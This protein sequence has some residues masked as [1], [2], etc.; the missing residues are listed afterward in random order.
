M[1]NKI[2]KSIIVVFSLV[3][4]MRVITMLTADCLYRMS[5]VAEEDKI[6]IDRGVACL[7]IATKF[8]PANADLYFRK[9]ELLDIK[10]KNQKPTIK[11]EIR[12]QELTLLRQCVQLCP[13][14]P[15]YHLFYALTLGQMNTRPNFITQQKILSELEKAS[16]L[17]PY[18]T[19]YRKIYKTYLNKF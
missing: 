2:L 13:S 18:S 9:Y 1:K 17:K 4:A 11:N 16:E 7:N 8:D 5:K 19:L 12:K 15:A 14:W 6:P 3:F 10:A